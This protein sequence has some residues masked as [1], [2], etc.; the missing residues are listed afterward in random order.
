[1]PL[2]PRKQPK[3]SEGLLC[4]KSYCAIHGRPYSVYRERSIKNNLRFYKDDEHDVHVSDRRDRKLWEDLVFEKVAAFQGVAQVSLEKIK[5]PRQ[6]FT[7]GSVL[8][9]YA[10]LD[11]SKVIKS[12]SR[13]V[14][15]SGVRIVEWP[16][17]TF[18][19]IS[20]IPSDA[21]DAGLIISPSSI[22]TNYQGEIVFNIFNS[23]NKIFVVE[24]LRPIAH[25]TIA[26]CFEAPI[27]YSLPNTSRRVEFSPDPFVSAE[28]SC[29]DDQVCFF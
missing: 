12:L 23:D 19:A 29:D 9:F 8:E 22:E 11:S 16:S 1:M 5:I 13:E 18:L 28:S 14:I 6:I 7:D 3:C 21:V 10:A 26:Q 4:F 24:P 2:F 20:A 15:S 25:V 17:E 27:Y